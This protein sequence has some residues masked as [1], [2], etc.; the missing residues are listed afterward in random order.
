M[1]VIKRLREGVAVALLLDRPA[2]E[3]AATVQLFGRPF[4]AS[5]GPAELA[6]ASGA[7][8]LPVVIVEDDGRYSV[9]VLGRIE[10]DRAEL[11]NPAARVKLTQ[12]L[13]RAFEPVL[14]QYPDQW[15]HFV[16]IW[17]EPS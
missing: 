15:Y 2:K 17:P 8:V 16:P 6:R 10:Y 14:Q 11:R 4:H 1:E 9:Q 7:A 13:L 12:D 5:I 3:T